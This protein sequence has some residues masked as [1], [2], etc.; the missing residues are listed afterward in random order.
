MANEVIPF[1]Q[2]EVP[3]HLASVFTETNIDPRATINQL[4]YRGKTWRRIVDGEE[5]KLTKKDADGDV[6][7]VSI[8]N[9]V[10]LDHN[11]K[12]SRAYYEG[13]FV[14]GKNAQPTCASSDGI[15]PDASIAEPCAATCATCP[16]S[17]KGSK[18]TPDGK[19]TTL[20]SP[21]KRIAVVPSGVK[22]ITEHPPLLLRLAQTSVWDKDA[23]GEDGWYAYDQYL[24]MLRARGVPHTAAVETRV[25]FDMEKAY[26]K[27]LFSAS[28]WL[29]PDEAAAAKMKLAKDKDILTKICNGAGEND[30]M[31]GQPA[32]VE[33]EPAAVTA[34]PK[35]AAP[36]GPSAAEVAAAQAAKEAEVAAAAKATAKAERVK[37]AAAALAAAQ[38]AAAAAASEDDDEGGFGAVATATPVEH[39][40]AEPVEKPAKAAAPKPTA[41]PV[42]VLE[43]TPDGV[44]ALLEGWDDPS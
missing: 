17:V 32:P 18:I 36:A 22:M 34:T 29:N 6:V 35:A 13:D 8:V 25:K 2:A 41:P 15:T 9:L 16:N 20:C 33:R 23:K 26:P 38:A 3:A 11:K 44:K 24:D 10:I 30:G 4:S 21:F 7:P 1:A 12:R 42:D 39:V 28:R 40:Q 31:A 19:P 37:A 43:G 5:T 27:L 14:E